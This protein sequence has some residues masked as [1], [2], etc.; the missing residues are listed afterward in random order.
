[1]ML[2]QHHS[3]E[4]ASPKQSPKTQQQTNIFSTKSGSSSA[5]LTVRT[6]EQPPTQEEEEDDN[7]NDNENENENDNNSDNNRSNININSNSNNIN[8][9]E[10]HDSTLFEMDTFS[11]SNSHKMRIKVLSCAGNTKQELSTWKLL[12]WVKLASI[13]MAVGGL[14]AVIVIFNKVIFQHYLPAILHFIK[15]LGIWGCFMY[16]GIFAFATIFVVPGSLLTLCGGF[17]FGLYLGTLLAWAGACVGSTLAF[18]NGRYFFHDWVQRKTSKFPRFAAVDAAAANRGWFIVL[19][20]R[21]TP[22]LPFNL[23]NYALSLTRVHP[24]HYILSTMVGV[25]PGT[26]LDAYFGSL[27]ADLADVASGKV[28][29]TPKVQIVLWVVSGFMIIV[30]VV[31]LTIIAKRAVAKT[32][33]EQEYMIPG[34]SATN[35]TIE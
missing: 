27:A 10:K 7:D 34:D 20:F 18:F 21:L 23:L 25:L 6:E 22:V 12:T 17:M 16:I 35:F 4:T 1:M 19:L 32:M 33:A 30:S 15:R 2:T 14:I 5:Y 11:S 26:V 24:V 29:P 3:M 8:I 28:G 9:I 31:V 13:L